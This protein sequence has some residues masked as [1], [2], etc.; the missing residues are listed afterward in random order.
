[1]KQVSNHVMSNRN[2]SSHCGLTMMLAGLSTLPILSLSVLLLLRCRRS[3]STFLS[4]AVTAGE[5]TPTVLRTCT[6]RVWWCCD[7]MW[8]KR[9]TFCAGV[10]L[11]NCGVLDG[12]EWSSFSSGSSYM[13]IKNTLWQKY[14]NTKF[15]KWTNKDKQSPISYQFWMFDVWYFPTESVI[16]LWKIR[17][18][19]KFI[20]YI[21]LLHFL[22]CHHLQVQAEI[23][24]ISKPSFFVKYL[25]SKLHAPNIQF[26]DMFPTSNLG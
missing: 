22:P 11:C 4:P 8:P 21:T 10:R 5:L 25:I 6:E 17:K 16:D 12:G 19:C 7:V 14:S 3:K 2:T 9:E 15:S 20:W 18:H 13:R 26:I 1:M 23:R 24:I